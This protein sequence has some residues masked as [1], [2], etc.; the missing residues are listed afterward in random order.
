MPS[1][2]TIEVQAHGGKALDSLKKSLISLTP[3]AVPVAATFGTVAA[4]A[5]A[6]TVATAAFGA[7][8]GPQIKLMSEA[9]K[10]EA[11]LAGNL[12]SL[13]PATREAAKSFLQ[14]KNSYRAWSDDLADDTMPVVNKSLLTMAAILPG[15]DGMVEGVATQYDRLITLLAGGVAGGAF[16]TMTDQ[17]AEAS[18]GA[19]QDFTDNVVHLSRV[20]SE[21]S[22]DGPIREFIQYARENGPAVR[23]TLGSIGEAVMNLI[24]AMAV[25]GP[26]ALT[27]V[28]ALAQMVAAVPPE[29]LGTLL[30]LYT[31]FKLVSVAASAFAVLPALFAGTGAALATLTAASAAAGGG[32]AGLRAAFMALSVTVRAALITTG[33]GAIV[34]A[35]ASLSSMGQDAPPD[36][37][38]VTSSLKRLGETG[39]NSGEA[40]R[41]FGDDFSKLGD[42]L[43]KVTDPEG[44]DQFQQSIVSFFG[45]DSTPIKDAK[46]NLD[47]FDKGLANLVKSGNAQQAEAA[48]KATIEALEADGAD[49]G[50]LRSQL[51]DYDEALADLAFE[52]QMAA[53]SMGVFGQAAQ[54]TQAKLN[55]QKQ[56]ADGLRESLNAL[57]NANLI[58]RGGIRGMEAAIDAANEAVGKNGAT[59]DENTA[60]GRDNAAALDALV[61]ATMK[62]AESALENGSSWE[63]AN[64]IYARGREN[65][66]ATATQMGL[67]QEAA[68]A[69]AEQILQIPDADARIEMDKEDAQADL[70]TFFAALE[71]Q[72]DAKSITI[73]ALTQAGE[74]ALEAMGL[75]VERM[76]DGSVTISAITGQAINGIGSVQ[77]ARD[78][79][80]DK[81][82]TITTVRRTVHEIVQGAISDSAAGIAGQAARFGAGGATGGL[83]TGRSFKRGYAQG[84]KVIGPGS[85]T[86]DDVFA[87]WLS[88][89][90]FVMKKTAVDRY[91]EKFMQLLNEGRINMPKYAKGGKVSEAERA[92]R[93]AVSQIRADTTVSHF[94]RMAGWRDAE[95]SSAIGK[96]DSVQDV[97]TGLTNMRALIQKG[98]SGGTES[99]LLKMLNQGG[100]NLLHHQKV[101]G[102]V[103]AALEKAKDKLDDLRD[104]AAQLRESVKNG[105][106]GESKITK[107]ARSSDSQV[108]INTLLGQ[109][110]ADAAN[111]KQF[112][113][114]LADLK[115]KGLSGDL[116]EQIA[117]A[118]IEG[119]GMETAAALLGGGKNEI[120]RIND[121]QKQIVSNADATGKT[122]ADAMYGAGIKAAEGLVKG[123]QSQ[124]DQIESHMLLLAKN[125]EKAIKKALGIKSPSKV[126]EE[127]GEFTA[128]GFALGIERNKRVKPA[129][130]SML[131]VPTSAGSSRSLPAGRSS[132]PVVLEIHSSGNP[133]DEFLVEIF[134]KIIRVRGGNVQAVL[135]R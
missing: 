57:N 127:V 7:A 52:Q 96:G 17:L 59:L 39:K 40:A 107:G 118:G 135:G 111:S 53:Q 58:A 79:L 93:D 71:E 8:L 80:S 66:I 134:R 6:A 95:F 47:A 112:S 69:L 74:E 120:K 81:T 73:D 75:K 97:V 124:Q 91:G 14:L 78:N 88:N 110:T 30:K 56:S 33:V 128:E 26:S 65:L 54:D 5:G 133:M 27:I 34:V 9:A 98:T 20:M 31:A 28:N 24:N 100:Q 106:I 1:V 105:I 94:G 35:L 61:V 68:A 92:R 84:G 76:P 22:A 90:E 72:P 19:L 123:L 131:N 114:M 42:S 101:L 48:L 122:A 108:T 36:I 37:D 109:M 60:A 82:V 125:M 45:T 11:T 25:A 38:K 87:P 67:S 62:A 126:M 83:Y 12:G 86:S 77:A 23:E 116:I 115:K 104:S 89:G 10:S 119:G 103:N 99:R 85:G 32:L 51:G 43:K 121:L 41:A 50:K 102:K 64:G 2:I 13:P 15:L 4:Q 21:G 44:L 129:W 130:A 63:E 3:A 18:S 132:E 113:T 117:E 46:E 16:T 55:A 29:F 49:T 70:E